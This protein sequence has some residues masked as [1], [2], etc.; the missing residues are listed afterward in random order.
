[1]TLNRLYNDTQL[2]GSNPSPKTVVSLFRD[3]CRN[4]LIHN[5]CLFKIEG[6]FPHIPYSSFNKYLL[7]SCLLRIFAEDTVVTKTGRN[8]CPHEIYILVWSDMQ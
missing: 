8:L 7:S 1:M 4:I 3:T 5:F 2:I 6:F